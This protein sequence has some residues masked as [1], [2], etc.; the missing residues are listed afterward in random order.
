MSAGRARAR[1]SDA[2]GQ[3]ATRANCTNMGLSLSALRASLWP[4]E[5][6]ESGANYFAIMTPAPAKRGRRDEL[7]DRSRAHLA[8]RLL[9]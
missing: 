8:A 9:E 1:T 6:C 2:E 5:Q 4:G 7:R 3:A